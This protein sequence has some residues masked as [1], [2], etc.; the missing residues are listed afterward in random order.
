ML[1]DL[2]FKSGAR[3]A[4]LESFAIC[5]FVVVVPE[6]R[7]MRI[8]ASLLAASIGI[9]QISV[10]RYY[11]VPLDVQVAA[12][13]L[14]QW[15]PIKPVIMKAM[16]LA[17][18]WTLGVAA[19]ELGVMELASRAPFA[20]VKVPVIVLAALAGLL[21]GA[22]RH[23]TPE[24]RALNALW[25]LKERRPPPDT[26]KV[27]LAPLYTERAR[28][29][30]VMFVLTESVRAEDYG[31]TT[32][33]EH[34]KVPGR[35]DFSQMRAVASFTML[36]L[37]AILTGRTQ[38]GPREDIL[39]SPTMFDY[40]HF[41]RDPSGRHL[42][43]VHVSGQ[44]QWVL[45][46]PALRAN[47]ED[48]TAAESIAGHDP[49][50]DDP[51]RAMD[52][53][54]VDTLVGRL[55]K[56]EGPFFAFVHFTDTHAPYFVD[57]NLAPF[58]PYDHSPAW[59]KMNEL[60]NAYRNSI[61]MQDRVL[62]RA[63]AAFI[64]RSGNEPWI[65]FFTSDHGEAFSDHGAIHHGQNLYDEQVHVP[66]WIASGNGAF[67]A[68]QMAALSGHADRFVTHLDLLPTFLDAIGLHD[69]FGVDRSKLP[70]RSMLRPWVSRDAFPVTNC[71]EMFKCP[72]NTWGLY[73]ND[74][75]LQARI[76]DNSWTC[77]VTGPGPELS[78]GDPVCEHLRA[79]SRKRFPLLP[80]GDPNR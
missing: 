48:F 23:A 6:R 67:D 74:H 79:E 26:G 60:H 13:A 72:V 18:V 35:V 53:L 56:V 3:V 29:P 78:I 1:L 36:S 27:Q 80:N 58:T 62:A 22:P 51:P 28:L 12:S 39:R 7:W 52:D 4:W 42:A 41:A 64:A 32:A 25:A 75:K 17:I 2:A 14:H 16:P 38:E 10:Y 59:S 44:S 69:V 55:A 5:A 15:G 37:S 43:T 20:R 46:T 24:V 47:I 77:T 61:L 63:V 40:A 45:E 19:I 33:P 50:E 65:V 68:A 34:T 49:E 30:N 9:A 73:E 11:H 70:G 71:T 76:F 66:A 21:S 31:A 54:V 57:P 8:V